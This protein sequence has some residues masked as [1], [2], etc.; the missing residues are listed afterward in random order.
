[1]HTKVAGI[2]NARKRHRRVA[3]VMAGL[4]VVFTALAFL[5]PMPP[6]GNA[7]FGVGALATPLAAMTVLI[8]IGRSAY[9]AIFIIAVIVLVLGAVMVAVPLY[10]PTS[11]AIF[12]NDSLG[13][14]R[15]MS[16]AIGVVAVAW[17]TFTALPAAVARRRL[18]RGLAVG[19]GTAIMTGV[20]SVIVVA[21]SVF[22][23]R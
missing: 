3:L 20:P 21:L 1:M 15:L 12:P 23:L 11:R 10:P 2:S 9:V 7:I 16:L 22:I 18:R 4:L 17:G 19:R 8:L 6:S 14:A 13:V 5:L